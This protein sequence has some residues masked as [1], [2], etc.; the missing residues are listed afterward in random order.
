MT[1]DELQAQRDKLVA[2]LGRS[3]SSIAF[4]GRKTEF[5]SSED[6]LRS[7]A[8]IDNEMAPMSGSGRRTF[9]VVSNSGLS[10]CGHEAGCSCGDSYE[11]WR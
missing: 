3:E 10:S 4:E 8:A 9:V 6:L 7:I 5:R 1:L 11:A 2:A